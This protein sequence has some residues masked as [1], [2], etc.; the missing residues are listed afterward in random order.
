MWCELMKAWV[1]PG[2]IL[3]ASSSSPS[4]SA[5]PLSSLNLS[6]YQPPDCPCPD[7]PGTHGHQGAWHSL[8]RSLFLCR[9]QTRS[10]IPSFLQGQ[11]R[12]GEPP[13]RL[14]GNS[15]S[16]PQQLRAW[17]RP[18][19]GAA[20]K[21]GSLGP[22]APGQPVLTGGSQGSGMLG[23]ALGSAAGQPGAR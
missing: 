3:P 10:T 17:A 16:E 20:G 18:P 19:C 4:P 9:A 5:L 11:P 1:E 13:S 14:L 22:P 6:N 21:A 15:A 2:P 7:R 23:K 8:L 12:P